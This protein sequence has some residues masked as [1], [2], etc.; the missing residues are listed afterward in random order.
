M[1]SPNKV[2]ASDR[3]ND[4]LTERYQS[5]HLY[6]APQPADYEVFQPSSVSTVA[7][8]MPL[9]DVDP[10]PYEELERYMRQTTGDGQDNDRVYETVKNISTQEKERGS[11]AD[12]HIYF[13]LEP[14]DDMHV[15]S[16][17]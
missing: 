7:S 16:Q 8:N 2:G 6:A 13:T 4:S 11:S 17:V 5:P 15:S 14:R 1:C 3:D 9:L 12:G 10:Q